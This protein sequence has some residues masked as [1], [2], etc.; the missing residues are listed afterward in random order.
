M[1]SPEP[2]CAE[3]LLPLQNP[4]AHTL[5]ETFYLPRLKQDARCPSTLEWQVVS[6]PEGSRNTG[7]RWRV[8]PFAMPLFGN[9]VA[10]ASEVVGS[11][12][13]VD[14]SNQGITQVE[15]KLR[16]RGP[17]IDMKDVAFSIV[18]Q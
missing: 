17:S 10:D 3:A 13:Q 18:P 8:Q 9:S 16:I 1:T 4:R 12:T 15:G 14:P 6:A 7:V 5:G 11:V 2:V